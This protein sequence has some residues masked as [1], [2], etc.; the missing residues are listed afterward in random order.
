MDIL[1]KKIIARERA[2]KWYKDNTERAKV[3]VKKYQI[4]NK[5]K[6]REFHKKWAMANRDKMRASAKKS[7]TAHREERNAWAREHKREKLALNPELVRAKAREWKKNNPDKVKESN[8]KWHK[9]YAKKYPEKL[10][11]KN[12]TRRALKKAVNICAGADMELLRL[13]YLHCPKGY[14]VDHIRPLAKGGMHHP[15][16]LQYL[17][18]LI[19]VQ[20]QDKLDFDCSRFVIRWESFIEGDQEAEKIQKRKK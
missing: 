11:E 18:A 10:R 6:C 3:N 16:N 20:K 9:D 7:Y 17:P 15:N 5:D 13:I 12:A 1:E 4:E 19:N 2:N 8:K 14:H